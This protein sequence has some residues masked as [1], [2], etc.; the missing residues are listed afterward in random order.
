MLAAAVNGSR[1]VPKLDVSA[2]S[3][4][5]MAGV[6]RARAARRSRRGRAVSSRASNGPQH[7]AHDAHGVGAC[8]R[9]GQRQPGR[10]GRQAAQARFVA[11]SAAAS[12]SPSAPWHS[13]TAA[14]GRRRASATSKS[15]TSGRRW[16]RAS[17]R[18]RRAGWPT[19]FRARCVAMRLCARRPAPSAS[20]SRTSTTA[21]TTRGRRDRV[22]RRT[23]PVRRFAMMML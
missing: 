4:G 13:A 14:T 6:A 10:F 19:R 8:R 23:T 21:S 1:R 2:P 12:P 20:E 22:R 11:R 5:Q 17:C 18:S 15:G 16:R 9:S 7:A 3:A